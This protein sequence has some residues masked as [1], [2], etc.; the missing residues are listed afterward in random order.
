MTPVCRIILLA[1]NNFHSIITTSKIFE[2]RKVKILIGIFSHFSIIKNLNQN[3]V[4][5]W[6][7]ISPQYIK[8]LTDNDILK[9]QEELEHQ[10]MFGLYKRN[11][12]IEQYYFKRKK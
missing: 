4:I 12:R 1:L 8:E 2:K 10:Y 5:G 9:Y 3:K 6:D 11:T 7:L